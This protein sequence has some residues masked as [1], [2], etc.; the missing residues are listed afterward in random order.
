MFYHRAV[1]SYKGSNYFGWQDLGAGEEKPTLQ[2]AIHQVLKKICKYQE[3][4]IAAA[5]RT[6]AG[7]HAQG[8]VV[9][10]AL[11][12][13]IESEKLLQG[14]NSLLPDD[15]RVLK[16]EACQAGFNPNRDSNSKKYHYYFCVD[17][18]SNPVLHDI[19]AHVPSISEGQTASD[20]Q[21]ASDD[22]KTGT[23]DLE[24]M[25]QACEIFIGE[26]DFYSFAA[27][28]ANIASTVRKISSCEILRAKFS[29][30]GNEIYCMEIEGDGFLKHMVRYIVAALFEVGR[31]NLG[32]DDISEAL[33]DRQQEK[34]SA[35]AKSC[36]LHLIEIC[37]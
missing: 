21:T 14:M 18:I 34:L 22:Q 10:F 16:C 15:I 23:I 8:Q 33:K 24:M 35:K 36:G 25:Q 37:Y 29:S 32:L 5:S 9:K 27:R 26:H 30:F 6:D 13:E 19:V 4:G 28:D 3:C 11:P 1:I 7:V 20:N 12:I 31:G 2:A 17:R